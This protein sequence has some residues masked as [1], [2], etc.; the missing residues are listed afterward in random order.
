MYTSPSTDRGSDHPK[1][2][3]V[4]ELVSTLWRQC[5]QGDYTLAREV[6]G[7]EEQVGVGVSDLCG[8]G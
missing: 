3:Q 8:G 5:A 1:I 2:K 7:R 6:V 4:A